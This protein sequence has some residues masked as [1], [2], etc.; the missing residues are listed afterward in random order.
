MGC[1]TQ[2]ALRRGW[3]NCLEWEYFDVLGNCLRQRQRVRPGLERW[4]RFYRELDALGAWSWQAHYEPREWSTDGN[5][6]EVRVAVGGRRLASGGYNAFPPVGEEFEGIAWPRF[7]AA[8]SRLVGARPFWLYRWSP[9][10][11]EYGRYWDELDAQSG[12]APVPDYLR[13]K[14][15]DGGAP[16]SGE[17][18][19][20]E[21]GRLVFEAFSK[22]SQ[23]SRIV[24]RPQGFQWEAFWRWLDGAGT[25]AELKGSMEAVDLASPQWEAEVCRAEQ[26]LSLRGV[27]ACGEQW[28]E[29]VRLCRL[30]K[31]LLGGFAI[32]P[33]AVR[34]NR[35]VQAT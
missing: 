10:G 7:C 12:A 13:V 2:V 5:H 29:F 32:G 4:R 21:E 19:Y 33:E 18:V 8:V 24:L 1:A 25:E 16:F 14:Y 3:R 17:L 6:W 28:P 22:G 30:L 11:I 35:L 9:Y 15:L 27:G 20:W 23:A 31:I 34:L 26:R